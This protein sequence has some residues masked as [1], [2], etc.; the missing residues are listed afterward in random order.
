[1]PSNQ[2]QSSPQ[3]P[4][5]VKNTVGQV[6]PRQPGGILSAPQAPTQLLQQKAA[7]ECREK[8]KRKEL[9]SCDT[10]HSAARLLSHNHSISLDDGQTETGDPFAR[11]RSDAGSRRAGGR[12]QSQIPVS[13]FKCFVKTSTSLTAESWEKE[14]AEQQGRAPRR[15]LSQSLPPDGLSLVPFPEN[16]A[17]GKEGTAL[18]KWKAV[19]AVAAAAQAT[20]FTLE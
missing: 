6:F 4:P 13:E 8:V 2:G 1:M 18:G 11:Y 5:L 16:P 17:Q 19:A 7:V 10:R 12:L 3:L 9:G 20:P 14:P 15:D